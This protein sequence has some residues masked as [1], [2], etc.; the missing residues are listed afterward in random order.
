[1]S[2]TKATIRIY[3]DNADFKIH[4]FLKWLNRANFFKPIYC[5]TDRG[6]HYKKI[7]FTKNNFEKIIFNEKK[8]SKKNFQGL[9]VF[10]LIFPVTK[11]ILYLIINI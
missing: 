7:L 11:C 1:M 2:D 3:F 4:N 6:N 9:K 10:F 5:E 8:K